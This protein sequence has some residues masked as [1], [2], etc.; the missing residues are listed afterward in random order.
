MHGALTLRQ[1]FVGRLA[2]QAH[3]E[4]LA[5]RWQEGEDPRDLAEEA[6]APPGGPVLR[7]RAPE[8][9]AE[10]FGAPFAEAVQA[11]PL[12]Q[13]QVVASTAGWHV[14]AVQERR[15]G[16]AL[17]FDEAHARLVL[18]WKA[19]WLSTASEA[20]FEARAE[21]YQIVGWPP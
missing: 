5:A 13:P 12:G 3:A 19:E 7:G 14:V 4:V 20:A 8:R 9:L 15:E 18:R 11:A 2:G 17:S 10:L 21:R 16:R 6:E 1:L